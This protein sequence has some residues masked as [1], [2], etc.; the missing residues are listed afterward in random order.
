M[1]WSEFENNTC[2]E[3]T[4]YVKGVNPDLISILR[5]EFYS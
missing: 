3:A 2:K 5:I 4:I 1:Q